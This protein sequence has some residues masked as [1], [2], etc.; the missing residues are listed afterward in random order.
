MEKQ[1]LH[2]RD[3]SEGCTTSW[4]S[5]TCPRGQVFFVV[6]VFLFWVISCWKWR[7]YH[8][9]ILQPPDSSCH[10][11]PDHVSGGLTDC[12]SFIPRRLLQ[13]EMGLTFHSQSF[14]P[15]LSSSQSHGRCQSL[16]MTPISPICS[17]T[18]ARWNTHVSACTKSR[19]CVQ[20]ETVTARRRSKLGWKT[21]TATLQRRFH[22]RKWTGK[23]TALREEGNAG[24]S[25][26][27]RETSKRAISPLQMRLLCQAQDYYD[28]AEESPLKHQ[29][30]DRTEAARQ[31]PFL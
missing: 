7:Y 4:K 25:Q 27:S 11:S 30:R 26:L 22:P 21:M 23:G 12:D 18:C 10:N 17:C 2:N 3:A 1:I 29:K 9:S 24:G 14:P 20:P 16:E 8:A 31:H 28:A 19:I 6:V 15:E 13:A 5:D